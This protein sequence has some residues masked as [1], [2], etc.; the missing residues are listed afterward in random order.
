MYE[1]MTS[2]NSSSEQILGTILSYEKD[3][4][5]EARDNCLLIVNVFMFGFS[6]WLTVVFLWGVRTKCLYVDKLQL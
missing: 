3:F 4:G 2:T 5:E 6:W 1:S